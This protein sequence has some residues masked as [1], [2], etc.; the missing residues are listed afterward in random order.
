MS[1]SYV[2]APRGQ[3]GVSLDTVDK[4]GPSGRCNRTTHVQ[5]KLTN[6]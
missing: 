1:A 6:S 4:L 5:S 2:E 3:P